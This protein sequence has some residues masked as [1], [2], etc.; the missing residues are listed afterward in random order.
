VV[1]ELPSFAYKT[2]LSIH[3]N[4]GH[5]DAVRRIST[6]PMNTMFSV[7]NDRKMLAWQIVGDVNAIQ[8]KN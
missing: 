3:A 8:S 4:Y 7:G 5:R 1:K 2:T 6:G